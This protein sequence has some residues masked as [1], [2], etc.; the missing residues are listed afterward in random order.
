MEE[1]GLQCGLE[2][3][4]LG[5]KGHPRGESTGLHEVGWRE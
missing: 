1:A 4:S 2:G 5:G 3:E